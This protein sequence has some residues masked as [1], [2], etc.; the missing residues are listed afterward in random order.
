MIYDLKNEYQLLD[1]KNKVD[2]LIKEGS[3]VEVKKKNKN[4]TLP[5]NRYLHLILG[6]FACE[7]GSS[8]EEVKIDFFKRTCNK[9]IFERNKVNKSGLE[10]I[11]LRSSAELDT[12]DMTLA[13]DRFRNWASAK[14]GIYLPA[15][16]ENEFLLHIS[17][18]IER[19]KEYI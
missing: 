14:A 11:Y 18:E 3:V 7:Y 5:Q 13:I 8:L 1:F 6:W 9:T 16:N 10:V 4:R 2:A 17:N 19:N 15:P 12:G